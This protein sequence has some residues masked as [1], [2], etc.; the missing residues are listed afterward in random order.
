MRHA[1]W[2]FAVMLA[3]ALVVPLGVM[4]SGTASAHPLGNFTI[5]QFVRLNLYREAVRVHFVVD[6]A[7]IPTYQ[8]MQALDANGDGE[9]SDAET[10]AY[11]ESVAPGLVANLRLTVGGR[12]VPLTMLAGSASSRKASVDVMPSSWPGVDGRNV[13]PPTA[14]RMRSAVICLPAPVRRTVC[15]SASTARSSNTSTPAAARL[16]E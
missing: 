13:W 4:R 11:V 8:E 15:G 10:S 5:N 12:A 14:T 2:L 3:A 16:F 7:E 1:R 6:M 9:V